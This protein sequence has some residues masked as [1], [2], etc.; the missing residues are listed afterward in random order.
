MVGL[1]VG[2]AKAYARKVEYDEKL[3]DL[4]QKQADLTETYKNTVFNAAADLEDA[5]KALEANKAD[6]ALMRDNNARVA[7]KTIID[8]QAIADMEIADLQVEASE[9]IGSATQNLAMSGTR[10][11]TDS[12]GNVM[13]SGVFVTAQKSSNAIS[14]ALA[15]NALSFYSSAEQA[16]A[17]YL[18]SDLNIAAYQRQ[19]EENGTVTRDEA[20][21]IVGGTG[22]FGRTYDTYKLTYDQNY[23]ALDDDIKF[24]EGDGKK[25]N[26]IGMLTDIFGTAFG[27]ITNVFKLF[28]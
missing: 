16:K 1:A 24:M 8:Q 3:K 18:Q 15:R 22:K 28:G 11:M 4:K 9:A 5:N 19:I 14:K 26:N 20:G 2:G 13:N 6:T 17:S 7:S 23:R 12:K 27:G 21:N 25:L 10:R